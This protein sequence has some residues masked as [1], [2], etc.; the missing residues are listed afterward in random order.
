MAY[1]LK[2]ELLCTSKKSNAYKLK[3]SFDGYAGAEV[4]RNI[5]VDSPFVLRK[6]KADYVRGTS[7]DYSIREAVDFELYE[8]Y[9]NNPK[10][11]KAQ[12]YKGTDLIWSGYNLPQQYEAD[13]VRAPQTV[14]FTATD[15][16]GLLKNEKF[17]LTGTNT[18]LETI[19]YCIDKIGLGLGYSIAIN[20]FE[21]N[22]AT[23]RSPLAQ[24]DEDAYVF[25]NLDCYTVIEK[26]LNKYDAEITQVNGRWHI[27]RSTD[28]KSTRMLYTAAGAYDTTE[29]APAVLDL[30]YPDTAGVEVWPVGRLK[31][32]RE[33]GAKK[34]TIRHNF[35]R[36]NSLLNNYQFW[37]YAGGQFT[38][39]TQTG[40]FT[41]SQRIKDG[42]AYAFLSG[43][44][45]D[46]THKISQEIP[47]VNVAGEDFVFEI[48]FAPIGRA[49]GSI[50]GISSIM[51]TVK[52]VV[53]VGDGVDTWYLTKTG[54]STV[55][56]EIEEIVTA[57][58]ISPVW[59]RLKIVV[60]G[61]PCNGNLYVG[62]S[63]YYLSGSP[64]PGDSISG[65]AFSEPLAYFLHDGEQYPSG[66]ETVASFDDSTEPGD[67]GTIDLLT[68]DA[69]DYSNNGQ[70]YE[71][72]TRLADGTPTEGWENNEGV[73]TAYSQVIQLAR[74]LAS[75][76]RIARMKLSGMIK[77]SAAVS[78]NS[79]IKHAYNSDREFEIAE[80][81][82]DLY[83]ESYS[84]TLLELLTWSDESITFTTENENASSV[85]T[86]HSGGAIIGVG[87]G[88]ESG[89]SVIS[90]YFELMNPGGDE[91]IK[92]R[93]ALASAYELRA[94]AD[95]DPFS[96]DFWDSMPIASDTVL[97]GIKVGS[98]LS[99]LAGVLSADGD[100]LA[101]PSAGIVVSTGSAWSTPITDNSSNWNA[102]YGWGNHAS[103]GYAAGS[104]NHTGVYDPAGTGHTEAAA[105]VATHEGSYA[106][107][108]I[109]NGQ[110]AYGWGNHASAGYAA[111]N[112]N[113]SGVYDPAG[114]GHAEAAAHIATHEGTYAHANIANGQ[115]AYGWGNHASAGYAAGSH[116]HTGVYEPANANIQSHIS[117]NNQAHSDYLKNNASDTMTGTLTV[118]GD[119]I[120]YG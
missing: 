119:V 12:L 57:S 19:I 74:T 92:C 104:H 78:F 5:P 98:G 36:K 102:A 26:I 80:V 50:N 3:L 41:L 27:T 4:D 48:D 62:L 84:V 69:P 75:N 14:R 113:H 6:D 1:G 28:K 65:I 108:N 46:A 111:G 10:K 15:G 112:H 93:L 59:N 68:A 72:I 91:Y 63:R 81:Q 44:S 34:V 51:M 100:S 56:T 16:L 109:A 29:A 96:D 116:N 25:N 87:I 21:S 83:N 99:I 73:T 18:Q 101:Y 70:L 79:I 45:A 88:N 107:A 40:T 76:N 118:T 117:N 47:I 71:N 13:Y 55:L 2:Y 43:Y 53:A 9:A 52:M 7:L 35:G 103:A 97:G 22:H 20:L 106:H 90:S 82:W 17:T 32:S 85:E 105:H 66:L 8:F 30:G 37:R 64:R 94:F 54:W 114:T 49:A 38:G 39:W 115:T 33:P 120:A 31:E 89:S 11:I 24:T 60:D 67:M 42:K 95:F 86:S 61:L 77:A 58:L 23:N 110:T